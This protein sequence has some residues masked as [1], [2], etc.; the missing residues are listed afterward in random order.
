MSWRR[1]FGRTHQDA[2]RA[3]EFESHLEHAAQ[4][5]INQGD[6]PDEARRKARLRF[7]NP[8]VQRERVDDLNRPPVFDSLVRDLRFAVRMLRRA[9]SFSL[10]VI[11]TLSLVI[12]ATTAV[13]SLAHGVLLRRLPY[14]QSDRLG[15][16][17]PNVRYGDDVTTNQDVDGA[18]WE[19]VRDHAKSIEA[20]VAAEGVTNV[21]FV[22]DNTPSIAQELRVGAGYFHVL[23][24]SPVMGREFTRDED[25]PGGPALAILSYDFWQRELIGRKDVLGQTILLD[26]RATSVIGVM[27]Q[28]FRSLELPVDVWTPLRLTAATGAGTN[29][30]LIARLRSSVTWNEASNELRA[31]GKEPFRMIRRYQR[32]DI[33]ATL[34]LAPLGGVLVERGHSRDP[35]VLLAWAVGAVLLIACVN[36]AALSL[37]RGGTRV[38][39]IATRMALGSGRGAVIRQLM[40]ESMLM[41]I[42]GGAIGIAVGALA[43]EWLKGTGGVMFSQWKQVAIDGATLGVTVGLS[44]ITSLVFGLVPALQASRLDV[45][46]ALSEGGSRSIAGGARPTLRRMLVAAEVALGVV[47]LVAAGLLLRQFRDFEE[48]NPGFR[49]DHLYTASALLDARYG[50]VPAV[51]HLF[52]ASLDALDARGM[53]GAAVSRGLPYQRLMNLPIDIEGRPKADE[54]PSIASINYATP[55]FFATLGIPLKVGR[56]FTALDSSTSM[57]VAIVNEVFARI[58]FNSQSP[59]GKKL[60]VLNRPREI[61]GV[62]A[63]TQQFGAGFFLK[64]MSQSPLLASP[65]VFVPAAQAGGLLAGSSAVWTV[66]A[67]SQAEAAKALRQ[68]IG[69]V[70][71]LLPLGQVRSMTEVTAR[72]MATQRLMMTLVSV[73]AAAA[74]LLAAIG[75][76]GLITHSVAERQREFGIRLALGA[77]TTR[78]IVSVAQTGVVLAG[79]GAVI[80]GALSIPATRLIESSLFTISPHDPTT[81]VGASLLLLAIAAVSSVLPT[82]R[83]LRL[84]PAQTLR[85]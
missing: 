39:E 2:D 18:M 16:V 35:I 38:K 40:I 44:L 20:A 22:S 6:T 47:L 73:L 80:G 14:P 3:A 36:I 11:V 24:V 46:A 32:N 77:T 64:G 33:I 81:Y 84:D 74:I 25:Q 7:G 30:M 62:I 72:A 56:S 26:G 4:F 19:T 9:P 34:T 85:E 23:G 49:P 10:T 60:L 45:Q 28:N 66:R 54:N 1:F 21:N 13:F 65:T 55:R 27:P 59:L 52:D 75:L 79:I 58:F 17:R 82:F 29:W 42:I 50:S 31:F 41:A 43:L 5:Y 76:H 71:P 61:V 67:S 78:I 53:Q 12:G 83:I 8:R 57:P 48:V 68:A 70:D 63:N 37:A 15:V 51:I 69:E